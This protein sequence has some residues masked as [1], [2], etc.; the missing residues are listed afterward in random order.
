MKVASNPPLPAESAPTPWSTVLAGTVQRPLEHWTSNRSLGAPPQ[1]TDST[2]IPPFL[3]G[4]APPPSAQATVFLIVAGTWRLDAEL[5]D[6]GEFQQ[7][8]MLGLFTK[9]QIVVLPSEMPADV[10]LFGSGEPSAEV[11]ALPLADFFAAQRIKACTVPIRRAL[12]V[13]SQQL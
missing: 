8:R 13:W 11:V 2:T 10:R 6:A 12:L 4:D 9:D 3:F 7:R 5:L 1:E